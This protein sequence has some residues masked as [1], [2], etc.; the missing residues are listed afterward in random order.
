MAQ[1]LEGGDVTFL[2]LLEKGLAAADRAARSGG[3]EKPRERVFEDFSLRGAA[4][5][6]A[7]ALRIQERGEPFAGQ[8][9]L[10][11]KTRTMADLLAKHGDYAEA[12]NIYEQ[13]AGQAS[14]PAERESLRKRASELKALAE[15]SVAPAR[16]EPAPKQGSKSDLVSMLEALASRL[17]ARSIS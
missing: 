5:V 17:D 1:N 15:P 13:L 12:V 7:L 6:Q 16:E 11:V 4:E 14:D 10:A 9:P 8:R 3:F 2:D